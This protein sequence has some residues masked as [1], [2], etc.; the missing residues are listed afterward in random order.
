MKP[1]NKRLSLIVATM[2]A[3]AASVALILVAFEDN[4]VFF[5]SPSDLLK[6][7]PGPTQ[8]LR[9]GGLVKKDSIKREPGVT[10]VSFEVTDLNNS[11]PV[12]FNGILPDLFREEQGVVAEGRYRE[13]LFYATQIL[14]KHDEQYMPPEV[15]ESLKKSG[16][17]K[18][19]VELEK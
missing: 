9:I 5:Y 12:V 19:P 11:V 18:G 1:K 6:K 2:T 7:R 17:W 4:V 8:K 15:A 10:E 13:Q 14:A 16:K 3:L